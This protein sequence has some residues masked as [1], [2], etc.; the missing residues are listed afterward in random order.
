M[1]FRSPAGTAVVVKAA[2]EGTYAISSTTGASLAADNIL[3]ASN[4]I[5]ADGTQYVLAQLDETVGFAVAKTGSTISAG[6]GYLV[7]SAP[8]K[9]FYP[10]AED[11]ATA[12]EMVNGQSSMVNGSIFNLAGQRLSKMQKGMNIVNGKKLFR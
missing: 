12:I 9:A 11:N 4:G 2:A 10:F 8:V 5:V 1:L 7:L 3:Q 6:K